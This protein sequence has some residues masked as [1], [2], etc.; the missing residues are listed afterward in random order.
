[1]TTFWDRLSELDDEDR[2]RAVLETFVRM[3]LTVTSMQPYTHVRAQLESTHIRWQLLRADNDAVYEEKDIEFGS[4]ANHVAMLVLNKFTK[5]QPYNVARMVVKF[6]P[7]TLQIDV[8][9]ET[10]TPLISGVL[11]DE[12]MEEQIRRQLLSHIKEE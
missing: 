3:H 12:Q 10:N 2:Q 1:V 11:I 8:L 4:N 6:S 9:N 7:P 5:D